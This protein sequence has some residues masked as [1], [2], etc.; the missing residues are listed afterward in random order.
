MWKHMRE[1]VTYWVSCFLHIFCNKI[2]Q[3][4]LTALCFW[5]KCKASRWCGKSSVCSL[6]TVQQQEC[7]FQFW[8]KTTSG[9]SARNLLGIYYFFSLLLESN[10]YTVFY[11]ST[12]QLFSPNNKVMKEVFLYFFQ[13]GSAYFAWCILTLKLTISKGQRLQDDSSEMWLTKWPLSECCLHMWG[14][15]S[16]F[17]KKNEIIGGCVSESILFDFL[18]R[19]NWRNAIQASCLLA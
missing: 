10:L 7:V 6:V 19:V 1:W 5:V 2:Y 8:R 15:N 18:P 14:F 16:S 3:N 13:R 12:S 11:K 4:L 9:S 17:K